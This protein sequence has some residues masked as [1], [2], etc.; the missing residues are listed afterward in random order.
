M[1]GRIHLGHDILKLRKT[2]YAQQLLLLASAL[3][4][5]SYASIAAQA[6]QT[7]LFPGTGNNKSWLY[8]SSHMAPKSGYK[9]HRS[10]FGSRYKL[11]CC[12]HAGLFAAWF[13]SCCA[14]LAHRAWCAQGTVYVLFKTFLLLGPIL[15]RRSLHGRPA[16]SRGALL[17]NGGLREG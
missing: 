11:G 9:C 15:G 14:Q 12:G 3:H 5:P 1:Q 2:C 10:H 17:Q 16:A 6:S 8:S 13:D 4:F 7:H